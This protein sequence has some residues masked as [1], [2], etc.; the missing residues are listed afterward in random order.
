MAQQILSQ[1]TSWTSDTPVAVEPAAIN[2]LHTNAL[3]AQT[4][5]GWGCFLKGFIASDLQSAV[6][7]QTD[8]PQNAFKQIRWSCELIQCVWDS[9]AEHWKSRNGDKHSTTP[10]ETDQKKRE[11]L[12]TQAQELLQTKHLLLSRYKK[13]FQ[14]YAKLNNKRTNNLE[15]WVNTTKQTVH[16]LLNVNNQ[17]DDDP[18]NEQSDLS[19]NDTDTTHRPTRSA[20]T[21]R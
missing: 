21:A 6:N 13:M 14:S 20:H 16:Y 9:E 15:T 11:K 18:N 1:L 19:S 2:P 8:T 12:L 7:A 10:A 17:A 5:V 4:K 3:R